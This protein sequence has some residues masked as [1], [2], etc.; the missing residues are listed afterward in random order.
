[1]A[2]LI[3]IEGIDGSGKGTQARRLVDRL[4]QSG[5]RTQLISFPRYEVTFFGRAVAAFLNGQFGSLD[6]VHPFLA[7]LLFAG[8]R[9]ESRPMLS[10]AL[11]DFDVVVLDRYVASNVAHQ[12]AKLAGAERD[13]LCRSINQVEYDL[14]G[15]PRPDL[16]LLLDLNVGAAQTLIAQK[17]ARAY[18]DRAADIHEADA[19]YLTRVRELYLEMARREPNWSV[20]RCDSQDGLR[21][22]EE[23]S[24]EV[25][26]LVSTSAIEPAR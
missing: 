8:D 19:E 5:I 20:I 7:S 11:A 23:I 3:V 9:F 24:E 16:V 22:I 14:F 15:M 13:A 2:R 1:V 10:A 12:A 17:P 18:T 6:E 25:W 21:S 4:R 26:Q